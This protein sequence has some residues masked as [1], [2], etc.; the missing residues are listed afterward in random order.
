MTSCLPSGVKVE[1][2]N[3]GFFS[4]NVLVVVIGASR[5][6]GVEDCAG[7]FLTG[8]AETLAFTSDLV[9]DL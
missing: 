6:V 1:V 3:L 8:C 5:F 4:T 2:P 9:P 7:A